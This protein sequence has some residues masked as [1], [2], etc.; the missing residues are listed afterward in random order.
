MRVTQEFIKQLEDL[1]QTYKQE[2]NR[3]MKEGLL[4]EKTAKTYLRHS[5]TVVVPGAG[6]WKLNK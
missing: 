5:G 6:V 1:Y 4:G 3:K 2:V